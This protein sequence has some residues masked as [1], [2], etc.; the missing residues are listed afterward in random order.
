MTGGFVL[1][2]ARF[3]APRAAGRSPTVTAPPVLRPLPPR[4]TSLTAPFGGPTGAGTMPSVRPSDDWFAHLQL[5]AVAQRFSG[6][7]DRPAGDGPPAYRRGRGLWG[8]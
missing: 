7:T 6:R 2:A 5:R 4:E 3:R 1:P 8:T